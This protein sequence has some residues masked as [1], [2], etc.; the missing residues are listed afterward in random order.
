M[1][2]RIG[3]DAATLFESQFRANGGNTEAMIRNTLAEL[4]SRSQG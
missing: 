4:R 1:S 3:G 2:S